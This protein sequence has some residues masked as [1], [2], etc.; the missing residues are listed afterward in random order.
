MKITLKIKK[1]GGEAVFVAT[2]SYAGKETLKGMG[3]F[4]AKAE[5]PLY[6]DYFDYTLGVTCGWVKVIK[7]DDYVALT[8]KHI[9][10]LTSMG[11]NPQRGMEY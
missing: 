9:T 11:I 8:K 6:T 7:G 1:I 2:N 10:Q 3:Y 5:N 4:F